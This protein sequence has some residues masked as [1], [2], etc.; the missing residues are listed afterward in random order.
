MVVSTYLR[1][2]F[3]D[4]LIRGEHTSVVFLVGL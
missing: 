4:C 3:V 2:S 1:D